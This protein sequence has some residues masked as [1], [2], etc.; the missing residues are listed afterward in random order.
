MFTWT[1]INSKFQF[2][3]QELIYY[4]N[5]IINQFMIENNQII[6]FRSTY[7]FQNQSKYDCPNLSSTLF[8]L[9]NLLILKSPYHT[10]INRRKS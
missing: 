4:R 2:T 7:Y 9:Y 3:N 8:A 1:S 10:I 6:S 5:F